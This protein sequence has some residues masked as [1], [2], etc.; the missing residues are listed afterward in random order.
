MP[1]DK[2]IIKTR[3][4][5]LSLEQ[6]A[7]SQHGMAHLMKE[8]S[9]RYYVLYYAAKALNWNLAQYQL[10]Q[11]KALFRIGATLRPKYTEDLNGFSKAH[12]EPLSED[13]RAK[14]WKAFEEQ[15]KKSIQESD[16]FHEKYGYGYVHFVLPKHPPEMFK[17]E[18]D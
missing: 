14:D 3:H 7:E 17:L 4:G 9:E 12:F 2:I 11:V 16:K 6:L 15:Y 10:N 8:V 18:P 5:E 13:I 1:E